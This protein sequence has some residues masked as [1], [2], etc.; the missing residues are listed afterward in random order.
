MENIK[1]TQEIAN[2]A[3][4]ST[5]LLE[6]EDSNGQPL[7]FGSGFF[8][9]ENEVAT[10]FHVVEGAH[11]CS[12]KLF[13]QSERYT[14]EE[15]TALDVDNDLIILKIKD[16]DQKIV[17]TTALSLGDSD[18]VDIG[19]V[20]YALG[21]PAGLEGTIS[22]GIVS[23]I[24]N[25][26]PSQ[27]IFYTSIQFTAPISPGNSGGAVLNTKGEVIG[28]SVSLLPSLRSVASQNPED[29]QYINVA[30]NLNFAIPSNCLALLIKQRKKLNITTPLSK[31]KLE[32]ITY[33]DNLKWVGSA[34]FTF[35]LQNRS[36]KD[37]KNVVYS[38]SF[39]DK[40][41]N[42]IITDRAVYP[43][44][45]PSK[46]TKIVIRLSRYDTVDLQLV[47]NSNIQLLQNLGAIDYDEN[48]INDNATESVLIGLVD[49]L[50]SNMG[51]SNYSAVK[52]NVKRL[53]NS[54]HIHILDLEVVN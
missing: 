12:V 8:V 4:P 34:S 37:V 5:V 42:T 14:I 35:P 46:S 47:D 2:K 20:I 44:V 48:D 54:H 49:M 45:I 9:Q 40:E 27:N 24:R 51:H 43:W 30:Q 11:K 25:H 16:P 17:S 41:G 38:V 28:V 26:D 6:T 3:L 18:I 23:G 1:S 31:A 15:Y 7:G 53:T 33:I 10:N 36:S 22:D 32:R 39:K 21:N 19:E 13:G 29:E 52:P 50:L